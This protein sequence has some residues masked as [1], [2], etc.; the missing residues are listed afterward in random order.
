LKDNYG[1]RH[2][3]SRSFK[4]EEIE[5]EEES[6]EGSKIEFGQQVRIRIPDTRLMESFHTQTFWCPEQ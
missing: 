2:R 4:K 1:E 5:E 3:S 6:R